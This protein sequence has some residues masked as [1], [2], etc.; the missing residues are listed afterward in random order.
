MG[1][2]GE[3]RSLHLSLS[4]SSSAVAFGSHGSTTFRRRSVSDRRRVVLIRQG[5]EVMSE[6][7]DENVICKS[8]VHSDCAVEIEDAAATI[9][10]IVGENFDEFVR[11]KLRDFAERVIIEGENIAL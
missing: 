2:P 8:V 9:R 3:T 6:L 1:V 4:V 5:G 10:A 11:R 7:V